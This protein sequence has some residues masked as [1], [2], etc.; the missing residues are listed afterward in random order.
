METVDEN[1]CLELTKLW[2]KLKNKPDIIVFDLDYT[3]WPYYVDCHVNPPIK[4]NKQNII[5]DTENFQI[6]GFDHVPNI[7]KTLRENCLSP[8]QHLAIASRSTTPELA[9]Q[10]LDLLDWSKY[11]S[12]IQIYPKSKD[13]HMKKIQQE[14]NFERFENVLFF[15]DEHH[16]I[17]TTSRMG[18]RAVLV[19]P[20]N[21]VDLNTMKK[22]LEHFN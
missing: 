4:K 19:E 5:Y 20:S 3:L 2:N 13:N 10:S 11:F 17:V 22:G 12:S 21:G 7:L 16:N 14:L 6:R 9:R 8:N 18:V 15:D 1:I